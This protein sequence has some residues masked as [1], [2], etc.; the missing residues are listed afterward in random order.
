MYFKNYKDKVLYIIGNKTKI[1]FI[2][3]FL[4]I[5]ISLFETLS[6]AIVVPFLSILLKKNNGD[7]VD[8][9]FY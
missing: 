8:F 1:I 4:F 7:Q 5:I 9:P 2:F 6:L 3:L